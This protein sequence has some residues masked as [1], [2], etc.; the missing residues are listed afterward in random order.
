MTIITVF[1]FLHRFYFLQIDLGESKKC[2]VL[3]G[4]I[5]YS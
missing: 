2:F 3:D 4:F 5:I 1:L